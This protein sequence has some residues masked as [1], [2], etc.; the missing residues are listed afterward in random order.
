MREAALVGCGCLLCLSLPGDASWFTVKMSK[1][2]TSYSQFADDTAAC[3]RA[4]PFPGGLA[5][6]THV[7]PGGGYWDQ[8][9]SVSQRRFVDWQ[10]KFLDCMVARGY[11]ADP[12][13]Y[14]AAYVPYSRIAPRYTEQSE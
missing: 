4:S 11:R 5:D 2:G 7:V 12:N 10:L 6:R 3:H 8:R 14:P 1:P 13:G 9:Q